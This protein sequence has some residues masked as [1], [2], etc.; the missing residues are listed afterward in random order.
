MVKAFLLCA[1]MLIVLPVSIGLLLLRK[2][3]E[4]NNLLLALLVGFIFE[5]F[6]YQILAMPFL[7]LQ[8]TLKELTICWAGL[9]GLA[10]VISI[11]LL[12]KNRRFREIGGSVWETFKKYPKI[13]LIILVALVCFQAYFGFNYMHI[14]EDDSN[15]VAKAVVARQTNSLYAYDD[16]GNLS[17]TYPYRQFLSQ[18]PHFTATISMFCDIHPTILAHTI[19]PVI[20]LVHIYAVTFLV[21]SALFKEKGKKE[22]VKEES[23][24]ESKEENKDLRYE[25]ISIAILLIGM[26][27]V[28]GNFS[29]Y[30]LPVR[31]LTRIWQG[32][33]ILVGI[34]MPFILYLYLEKIGKTKSK[35]YYII[36]FMTMWGSILL[37]TMA[38][39]LPL[40]EVGIMALVIA[41][42]EKKLRYLLQLAIFAIPGIIHGI[43][44]FTTI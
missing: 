3:D 13:P 7:L 41:I 24:K 25:K 35:I 20:F 39:T 4:K 2:D 17:E 36:L 16:L 22:E 21:L 11:F 9:I 27:F 42:K 37:S 12:I 8:R 14:D 34:V 40:I 29:R 5:I 19:Y 15:F 28:M 44:Y 43:I 33:N 30:A 6:S 1:V 32:K 26:M 10:C 18:F 23:K 31:V 38:I